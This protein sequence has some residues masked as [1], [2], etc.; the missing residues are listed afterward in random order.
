V[1]LTIT[2]FIRSTSKNNLFLLTFAQ[3]MIRVLYEDNHLLVVWKPSG[4]VVQEGDRNIPSLQEAAKLYI[5]EKYNKPGD[6]FLGCVHRLDTAVTGAVIFARTSKALTRMNQLFKDRKIE[7][8]YLALIRKKPNPMAGRLTHYLK[9]DEKL[10]KTKLYDYE[11]QGSKLAELD[12]EFIATANHCFLLRVRPITGRPHQIRVQL[13]RTFTA[14]V[15]DSKY[16][17]TRPNDDK[18]I[19][20][21]AL[22]VKFIHPVSKENII[23]HAPLPEKGNWTFFTEIEKNLLPE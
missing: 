16:G 23:I 2:I 3:L 12:Y 10:N 5:K 22:G 18:S 7:K 20:L 9:K 4:M 13:A 21:H 15:G 1:P 14:I 6:V 19:Y 17:S 8:V 11:Q